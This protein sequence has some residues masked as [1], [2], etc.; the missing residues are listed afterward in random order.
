MVESAYHSA[1]CCNSSPLYFI[2]VED[3]VKDT[4]FASLLRSRDRNEK[5][6]YKDWHGGIGDLQDD[7]GWHTCSIE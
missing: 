3:S 1:T 7:F 6:E 4:R 5:Y 2:L